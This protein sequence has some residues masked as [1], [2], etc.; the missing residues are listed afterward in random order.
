MISALPLLP[1]PLAIALPLAPI[2]PFFSVRDTFRLPSVALPADAGRL[3]GR[4]VGEGGMKEVDAVDGCEGRVNGSGASGTRVATAI[5]LPMQSNTM[6][7]AKVRWILCREE[8][9][10]TPLI[11]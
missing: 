10:W 6:V 11:R 3:S 7:Q 8:R 9:V 5:I 4:E 1:L 2:D